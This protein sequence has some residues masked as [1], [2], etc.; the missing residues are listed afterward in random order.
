MRASIALALIVLGGCQGVLP[1]PDFE[2]M[3]NQQRAKPYAAQSLLPYG[4]TLQPPPM[5]AVPYVEPAARGR[6]AGQP[7][8]A[9][10][11]DPSGRDLASIPIP[12]DRPLL[13]RGRD[14]FDTLCAA[15]HGVTGDGQSEVARHMEHRRPP[16]LVDARVRAFPPGRIFRVVAGG[17]GLMPSYAWALDARDRWAVVAYLGALGMSQMARLDDLP[18][19]AR[20]QAEAALP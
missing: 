13:E 7:E 12:I 8:V 4:R 20:R 15:C 16:S 5:G 19:A 6:A 9:T 18:A 1:N 17:Y 3:L 14:R 10:G 11:L 2:R